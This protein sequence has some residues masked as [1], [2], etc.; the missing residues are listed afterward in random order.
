MGAHY[1]PSPPVS[2]LDFLFPK[3]CLGCGKKG[4]YFCPAC[5]N[6]AEIIG[7][8]VCPVCRRPSP[9]GRTHPKCQTRYALDGLTSVF[10]Y[11]G[12]IRKGIKD[13]KFRFRFDLSGELI[14]LL[15]NRNIVKSLQFLD[16]KRT[17]VVPIPLHPWREDWRGFNQAAV[18]AKILA[19]KL[20]LPF[21]ENLLVRTRYTESQTGLKK[22]E[23]QENVENAFKINEKYISVNQRRRPNETLGLKSGPWT[24]YQR[25]SESY[26]IQI[27]R[28]VI[29]FD[30]VWTTGA[31]MQTCANLLKR[32]GFEKVW[33]LTLAR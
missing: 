27:P 28:S 6:K 12:L 18:L 26:G 25:K 21:Y 19:E 3:K 22:E 14:S 4:K 2:F 15:L 29:L 16:L 5:L 31:T 23:R 13:L 9:F 7:F 33:G 20:N 11:R 32:A 8:P 1:S 10:A 17:I 24:A 30:D